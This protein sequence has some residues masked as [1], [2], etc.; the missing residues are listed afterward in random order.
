MERQMTYIFQNSYGSI[1]RFIMER[2]HMYLN[3]KRNE[4]EKF[5]DQTRSI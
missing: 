5:E 4:D 2:L 3:I 1:E